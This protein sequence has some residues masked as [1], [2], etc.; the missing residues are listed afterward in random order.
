MITP[1]PYVHFDVSSLGGS[2]SKFIKISLDKKEDWIYGIYHNS[3]Y[4]IFCISYG[5]MEIISKHFNMPKFRKCTV[6]N[7]EDVNDKL[8]KYYMKSISPV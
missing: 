5:K 8:N 2:V 4:A 6:K 3:R 7:D 1:F